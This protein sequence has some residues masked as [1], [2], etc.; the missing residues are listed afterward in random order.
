VRVRAS[1][2]NEA[3]NISILIWLDEAFGVT[4][5]TAHRRRALPKNKNMPPR[6]GW[7]LRPWEREKVA[8]GRMRV[9]RNG[10]G[11]YKDFVSDGAAANRSTHTP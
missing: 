3:M 8:V 1:R 4:P 9:V 10:A 5:K 2:P 6:R 11:G 7:V